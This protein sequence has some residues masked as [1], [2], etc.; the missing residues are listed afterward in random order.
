MDSQTTIRQW[1]SLHLLFLL[2]GLI[3]LAQLALSF[4]HQASITSA[5]LGFL[6]VVTLLFLL[7]RVR[8]II[9]AQSK[10]IE[11]LEHSL[12]TQRVIDPDTGAALP[13]WFSQAISTECRRAVREFA[14]LT[15]MQFDLR[16]PDPVTLASARVRLV[17]MLTEEVSRPG[18]LVGLSQYGEIELLLPNTNEQAERLAEHCI[19]TADRLLSAQGI[20]VRLAGCTLQP[21]AELTP[22]KVKEHLKRQ[23]EEVSGQ[24][25]GSYSYRA[26]P[27]DAGVLNSTFNL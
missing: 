15:M 4:S 23:L 11:D 24:P 25:A 9:S 14:P 19:A 5:L 21:R 12:I 16:G 7:V 26:E 17:S 20:E 13:E 27:V 6:A 22:E 2:V 3:V 8:A 18:D 1:R 10:R